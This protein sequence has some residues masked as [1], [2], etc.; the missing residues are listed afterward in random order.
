MINNKIQAYY[1]VNKINEDL[2]IGKMENLISQYLRSGIDVFSHQIYASTFAIS[3]PFVKG[4]ILADEAGLGKTMEALLILAQYRK[5]NNNCLVV[6]PSPTVDNWLQSIVRTFDF[7]CCV[8]DNIER[9]ISENYTTEFNRFDSGIV[10]TTY[11]YLANNAEKL[12]QKDWQLCILDEAHRFRTY[13][14]KENKTADIVLSITPN[15]KKILLTATPIQ[16]N[17]DDIFGLIN[18]IDDNIFTDYEE[19]H[20]KYFRK[21]ENYPELRDIIAPYTFR[22]LRSQVKVETKLPERRILTQIYK[23]TEQEKQ[24]YSLIEKYIAKPT[25]QAFPEMNPYELSLM[26]YGTLSSSAYALS[27]TLSGIYVRLNKSANEE[28][29]KEAKEIKEMLDLATSITINN[30]DKMLIKALEQIFSAFHKKGIAKKCVIFTANTQSQEH[31]HKLLTQYTNYS[32][33]SFNG[34]TDNEPINKFIKSDKPSILISTDKG[35]ESL[36]WQMS[37]FVVN[38]DF[39]QVLLDMEQ[40]ISRCHRIGQATDVFVINFICPENFSDVRMYELFYKRLNISN[41]IIGASDTIISGAIDGD[42][43]TNIKDTLD[44]VRK[45]KEVQIDFAEL[46]EELKEELESIKAESN[47]IL[48]NTFDK[49]LVE[50]T[51]NMAEIIKRKVAELDNTIK[52]LA[53][54]YFKD[55]FI[56]ENTFEFKTAWHNKNPYAKPFKFSLVK[57]SEYRPFTIS[58]EPCQKMISDMQYLFN[59]KPHKLVLKSDNEKLKGLKGYISAY[60]LSLNCGFE[61]INQQYCVGITESN[62]F[63]NHTTCDEILSLECL[64]F[65]E[66]YPIDESIKEKSNNHFE[67]LMPSITEPLIKELDKDAKLPISHIQMLAEKEKSKLEKEIKDLQREIDRV[68]NMSATDSFGEGLAKNQKINEL[69]EQLFELKDNEFIKKSKINRETKQ[70]IEEIYNKSLITNTKSDSFVLYFEVR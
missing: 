66:D 2:R 53:R 18:F 46:S 65:I 64:E 52:D 69:S 22:T 56:D 54:Y 14:I 67:A 8:L 7:R 32:V 33:N 62:E 58:S 43:E 51:K 25:K 10:L 23:M 5:R 59:I 40:R 21:P 63:L 28:N 57:D 70:K 30:K 31:I 3:N 35:N 41:N 1:L 20:K 27:K 50:K 60:K 12:K 17:E 26:L 15:A 6:V 47:D 16:K 55:K 68:K 38:Y 48:F 11:D 42:I 9:P 44:N 45:K 13:K 37:S 36:N 34:T 49:K 61:H 39:P 4:F 19:F 29:S 24:L